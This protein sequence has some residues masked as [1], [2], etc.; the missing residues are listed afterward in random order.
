MIKKLKLL[1]AS[2]K[3]PFIAHQASNGSTDLFLSASSQGILVRSGWTN[4][5]RKG[6][7][8]RK[9]NIEVK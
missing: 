7:R 4:G 3:D 8:K 1:R 6:T 2:A 5:F 9:R